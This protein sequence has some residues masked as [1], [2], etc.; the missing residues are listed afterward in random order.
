MSQLH[1][2]AV[3]GVINTL[4][5]CQAQW[6]TW[7]TGQY[8]MA[9]D[10]SGPV[11]SPLVQCI[12]CGF[13]V[14]R[15]ATLSSSFSLSHFPSCLHAHGIR[16]AHAILLNGNKNWIKSA[17]KLCKTLRAGVVRVSKSVPRGFERIYKGALDQK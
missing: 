17:Y 8:D 14:Q 7:S 2:E 5:E 9:I 12:D 10:F 13:Y 16:I 4:V 1:P 6:E 11:T 15:S 3:K